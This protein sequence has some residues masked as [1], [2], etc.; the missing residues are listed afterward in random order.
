MIALCGLTLEE[1]TGFCTAQG[2]PRFRAKQIAEWV[3]NKRTLSLDAMTNLPAHWRECLAS[4]AAVVTCSIASEQQSADCTRKLL[5][6]LHDGMA[7]ETVLIPEGSRRT[8][9][10]STQVGCAMAC[11]LCASGATGLE[12]SLTA[13]EI[14]GQVLLAQSLLPARERVSNLVYMG[15]GEPLA[16]YDAMLK[17]IRIANA[18]WALGIGARKITVSTVGLPGAIER[19]AHEDLQVTLAISLHAADDATRRKLLPVAAQTPLC[20]V[21]AAAQEWCR[22]TGRE[23]TFEYALL[24]G[25]NCS[26]SDADALAESLAGLRCSIN[27]IPFNPVPDSPFSSASEPEAAAFV[28]R[29]E[30]RGLNVNVRRRRGADIDAACGQLRLRERRAHAG[31]EG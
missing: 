6:R 28:H 12:R 29:L 4:Q 19:L 24:A 10:L 26:D 13:D 5:V 14:V 17:S 31:S 2:Q 1:L 9:C 11:R 22:V 23:V 16:N 27:V 3:F 15:M 20:D 30:A 8:V 18:D 25:V 7:V 21:L